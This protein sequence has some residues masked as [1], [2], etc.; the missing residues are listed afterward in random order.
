MLI[1][2]NIFNNMVWMTEQ[3]KYDT[4]EQL[5][6][7]TAGF[8]KTALNAGSSDIM[9]LENQRQLQYY[10]TIQKFRFG[11]RFDLTVN[12]DENVEDRLIPNLLLQPLVENAI[13]HGMQS[14]N[15]RGKI[16]VTASEKD[17]GILLSVED[18]GSGIDPERLRLIRETIQSGADNSD[19]FFALVNIAARLRSFDRASL[20]IQ[21][22]QEQYTRVEIWIPDLQREA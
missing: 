4:L 21:S 13:V 5:V 16:V 1:R 15:R 17:G 20:Q 18:N 22:V 19:Q 11:D 10:V 6:K 12:L 8:Y 7:S 3:K 9:L 14:L 2:F